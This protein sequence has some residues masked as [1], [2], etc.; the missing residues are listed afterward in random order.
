MKS[1][2][3]GGP[4]VSRHLVLEIGAESP[5]IRAMKSIALA[6]L[7]FPLLLTTVHA[8]EAAPA[9]AASNT[10]TAG[11]TAEGWKLL[12]N[13]QD[14]TG[15]SNFRSDTIK[16]GWQVQDSALVCVDPN[17][18]GDLATAEQYEWFEL[19]LEFK[20]G[21]G[22][23]SGVIFHASP[24]ERAAWATGP[25]LQ[26]EDNA[27]AADPERCGWLY[28]LY[29]PEIDPKTDR[30]L[31]ATKPAGE[32]NHLRLLISPEKCVHEINGVKYF[33]YV[34]GS[35]DFK[36]RV[37]ASKFGKMPNFAKIPKGHLVFQG[38]HGKVS[39]RNVK[40]REIKK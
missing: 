36:K 22:A 9:A 4:D 16:P 28:G 34:L 3:S 24:T 21:E 30:P 13:G 8:E 15:W 33:E 6:L 18:A 35:E 20:M 26:L 12:F 10:L 27:K 40:L 5:I 29:K 32:W 23:N 37:E 7:A 1:R 11:E 31:D 39:F 17:N 19:D 38:D 14:L 2:G 25:E